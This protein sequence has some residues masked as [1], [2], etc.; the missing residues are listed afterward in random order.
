MDYNERDNINLWWLKLA[1][2]AALMFAL[3]G[4]GLVVHRVFLRPRAQRNK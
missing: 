3:S 4:A 2:F 1:S